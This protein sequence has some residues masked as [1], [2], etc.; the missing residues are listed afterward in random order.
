MKS[1]PPTSGCRDRSAASASSACCRSR[2]TVTLISGT[3]SVSA[4]SYGY[5]SPGGTATWSR[6]IQPGRHE[7]HRTTIRGGAAGFAVVVH[8]GRRTGRTYRAPVNAFRRVDGFV[9]VL[10]YS[11]HTDWVA[12]VMAADGCRLVHL[13]RGVDVEQPV[14]VAKRP[15]RSASRT[16]CDRLLRVL[17]VREAL[18][19]LER[20]QL[21]PAQD[22]HALDVEG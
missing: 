9:I 20:T 21:T 19:L 14:L 13:G 2:A 1:V 10:T 8:T 16:C 7:P 6:T 17:G 3:L 18:L 5:R 11:S 15:R 22:P 12:N 4:E